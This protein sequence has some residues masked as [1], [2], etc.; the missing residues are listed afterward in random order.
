ELTLY[1]TEFEDSDPTLADWK[2]FAFSMDKKDFVTVGYKT[3]TVNGIYRFEQEVNTRVFAIYDKDLGTADVDISARGGA[4]F[5]GHGGLGLVCRYSEAGWYQFMVEPRGGVWTIRLVKPDENGQYHFHIIA[6]GGKWL[7]QKVDLRAECKG[8]RLTFYIDG[9]KMASLHDST[10]PTGKVGFLGWSFAIGDDWN[11]VDKFSARR[12][13][14]NETGLP[15]PAPT[16]GADGTI[17][18]T[19]FAKPDDLNP[20]WSKIDIG[21]QGVPGSPV[22][23]GGPGPSPH[24]YQYVNDFDPGTDVEITADVRGELNWPRGLICR[25]SEDGWYETFYMKDD[26]SHA[27]VA[28]VLGQRDEQGKLTRYIM[29]TYYPPK[30]DGSIKLTLTCAGNQISVKVNG[31]QALYTEDNTWRTGR[32][33]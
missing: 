23:V 28:L 14:W 3:W 31:E 29:D 16:P 8:D 19:E 15:G 12:A 30:A 32:Y 26:S 1:E 5:E 7:G 27:R 22:L 25:Y 10:F 20:Y 6:S 11:T 18:S 9:E 4:P 13:Q 21:I 2:T 33:G 17:Y 24:T